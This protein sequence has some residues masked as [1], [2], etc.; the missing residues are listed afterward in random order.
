MKNAAS[1]EAE[2]GGDAGDEGKNAEG[3]YG[4]SPAVGLG[5]CA[6]RLHS[7]TKR[8]FSCLCWITIS[9]VPHVSIK[10]LSRLL[11]PGPQS[12]PDERRFHFAGFIPSCGNRAMLVFPAMG[13]KSDTQMEKVLACHTVPPIEWSVKVMRKRTG[14]VRDRPQAPVSQMLVEMG[15]GACRGHV[16]CGENN[17]R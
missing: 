11:H 7:V 6:R 8:L 1:P 15:L 2:G 4:R 13:S 10:L 3:D 17:R 12:K 5:V 9:S 16:D 14:F